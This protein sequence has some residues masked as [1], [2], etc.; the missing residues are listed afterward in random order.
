MAALVKITEQ[1][2]RLTTL[3]MDSAL[4][5]LFEK[6][7]LG[8]E[9]PTR[10]RRPSVDVECEPRPSLMHASRIRQILDCCYLD[11]GPRIFHSQ[12]NGPNAPPAEVEGKI[13]KNKGKKEKN[14][15]QRAEQAEYACQQ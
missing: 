5:L 11:G 6:E 10:R 4:L 2:D 13:G 14:R 3:T 8:A 7:G 12:A 9:L 15:K 1:D